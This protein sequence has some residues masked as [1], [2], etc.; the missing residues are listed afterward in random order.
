MR[1]P[2]FFIVGAPRCGTTAMHEFLRQHPEIFLPRAG[3][4]PHFF[5]TDLSSPDW[6]YRDRHRYAKLFNKAGD[7]LRVGEKSTLYLYSQKA[8]AEIK[9]ECPEAD[10]IIMLRNP[11][12]ML[13]SYHGQ[14]LW[15]GAEN[16]ED[17]DAALQ[18][19]SERAQGR[20]I[21]R[22]MRVPVDLLLYSQV[23]KFSDQVK[24]YLNVFDR[25]KVWIIIYDDLKNATARVYRE[26]LEF[27]GVNP[28]FE[29]DWEVINANRQPRSRLLWKITAR[30]PQ[31][32]RNIWRA[33]FPDTMRWKAWDLLMFVNAVYKP[34]PPMNPVLRA[35]LQRE[36]R[37]EV[38]KLS[39]LIGRDL[40]FW[41][42]SKP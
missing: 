38:E 19:E 12:D 11:V 9:A 34:R 4:E 21:P 42:D 32:L 8:A 6:H 28:S 37:P 29:P 17:F 14:L 40:T 22:K 18:A 23:A 24:R 26:T 5:L 33:V 2:D 27:L 20:G 15:V 39:E 35:R 13:Y 41:C 10:I 31:W 3:L 36:F 25:S 7:A 30:D 1:I 16:L